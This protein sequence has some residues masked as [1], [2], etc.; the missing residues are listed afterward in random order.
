MKKG[1]K[2]KVLLNRKGISPGEFA[3]RL[4]ISESSVFK[5]YNK[6]SFDSDLLEKFCSELHVPIT[7]FFDEEE[8]TGNTTKVKGDHNNV[9]SGINSQVTI[10]ENDIQAKETEI[11]HLKQIINEKERLIQVLMKS[12]GK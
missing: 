7:Y 4:G 11:T 8:K 3:A 9:A 10:L 1:E 6:N 12:N 2:L 5:Y